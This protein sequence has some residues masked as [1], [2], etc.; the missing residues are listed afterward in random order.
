MHSVDTG[1]MIVCHCVATVHFR[2]KYVLVMQQP[3]CNMSIS[4]LY[5]AKFTF[6]DVLSTYISRT[7]SYHKLKN[8]YYIDT[9]QFHE[10]T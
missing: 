9:V 8:D 4:E 6:T 7:H 10:C 2:Y 1:V 3:L 5:K